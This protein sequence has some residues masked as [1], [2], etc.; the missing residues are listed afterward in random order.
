MRGI[1]TETH[2]APLPLPSR[3]AV[4]PTGKQIRIRGC[5]L[6][7]VE[8]GLIT[9]HHL[10][11]DQMEFSRAARPPSGCRFLTATSHGA[12]R[13]R[14]GQALLGVHADYFQAGRAL[15]DLRGDVA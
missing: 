12:R 15:T 4:A 1:F 7:T 3:E 6:A 9:Q 10:Y 13:A 2:T 14:P 11:F 5:D 8:G